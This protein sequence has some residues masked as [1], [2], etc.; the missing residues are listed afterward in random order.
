LGVITRIEES[1]GRLV[2]APFQQGSCPVD[3]VGI[4]IALKRFIESHRKPFFER[5]WVYPAY[6]IFLD[7]RLFFTENEPFLTRYRELLEAHTAAWLC[8]KGYGPPFPL[9][10]DF[11]ATDLC[12]KPFQIEISREHTAPQP[13]L[14]IMRSGDVFRLR[15]PVTLIGR[16]PHCGIHFPD[17]TVSLRHAMLTCENGALVLTDLDSRNGTRVNHLRISE[18]PLQEGDRI[19]FGGVACLFGSNLSR[20]RHTGGFGLQV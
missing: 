7:N 5:T 10:I 18:T 9:T 14:T 15:D 3:L 2:E 1:I 6:T 20:R 16:D 12:G 13:H 19:L 4:E 17:E 11:Q 8:E